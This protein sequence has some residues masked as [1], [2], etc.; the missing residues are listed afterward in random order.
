MSDIFDVITSQFGGQVL[1]SMSKQAG[2]DKK[3]AGTVLSAALPV[4]M[5]AMA[6]NTSRPGGA[7]ALLN[8]L[9]KD[10]DGSILNNVG[11]F[12]QDPQRGPGAGILKHVLGSKRGNV[13]NVVSHQTGVNAA[14]V[15]N[16]LEM[17]APILMGMLGKQQRQNNLDAGGLSNILKTGVDQM[18]QKSPATGGLLSQ[19][20]DK[21]G[22]GD[23]KDDVARMGFDLLGKLFRK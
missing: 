17:A 10:H 15:G 23:I 4:L 11:G 16:I 18:S 21:D 5:G 19:L 13:E 6:R 2:L 20:L 3:Q 9:K 14:T 12:L 22:D 1:D 8:A 7:D